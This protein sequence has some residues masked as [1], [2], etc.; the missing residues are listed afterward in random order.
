M[1]TSEYDIYQSIK[2]RCPHSFLL[3]SL[4]LDLLHHKKEKK[5]GGGSEDISYLLDRD[6]N[7]LSFNS[8]GNDML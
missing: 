1:M 5:K 4:L 6:I 8:A 3:F 2:S 7:V